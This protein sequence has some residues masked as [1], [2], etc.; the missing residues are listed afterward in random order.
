MLSLLDSK[1][2]TF[3]W[4]SICLDLLIHLEAIFSHNPWHSIICMQILGKILRLVFFCYTQSEIMALAFGHTSLLLW[5]L[6]PSH[7]YEG[8]IEQAPWPSAQSHI[9]H[10]ADPLINLKKRNFI[11]SPWPKEMTMFLNSVPS[12]WP[13]L[14][15]VHEF[16]AFSSHPW[17]RSPLLWLS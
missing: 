16:D 5:W 14:F 4:I 17:F 13:W 10:T 1:D 11:F 8:L 7:R 3:V 9:Q 12:F 2:K 6:F 15:T